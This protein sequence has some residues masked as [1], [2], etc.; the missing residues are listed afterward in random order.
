MVMV[1]VECP[2]HC[3]AIPDRGYFAI[4]ATGDPP[5]EGI[6]PRPRVLRA[7]GYFEPGGTRGGGWWHSG[8][9]AA[10]SRRMGGMAQGR[11]HKP[12]MVETG[13]CQHWQWRGE[14]PLHT[15]RSSRPRQG[16]QAWGGKRP[17]RWGRAGQPRPRYVLG[18]A[19][20]LAEL[21]HP[22]GAEGEEHVGDAGQVA[23]G[24]R[25]GTSRQ[26]VLGCA[27]APR[28][29]PTCSSRPRVGSSE[30]AA[31]GSWAR[32]MGPAPGCGHG[33]AR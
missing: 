3:R 5:T 16:V 20:D 28:C 8:W 14:R 11:G 30:S 10:G 33:Q 17:L 26:E 24:T 31:R 7:R 23:G 25:R 21:A 12:W 4:P 15:P 18:L 27:A 1:M 9:R 29:G 19:G 2:I 32:R 6:N 22:V 13:P